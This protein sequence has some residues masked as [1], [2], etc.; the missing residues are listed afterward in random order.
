MESAQPK[1]DAATP[2]QKPSIALMR[3]LNRMKEKPEQAIGYILMIIAYTIN[4][5][6]EINLSTSAILT[7]IRI[8]SPLIV[9]YFLTRLILVWRRT[10]NSI[11]SQWQIQLFL[12]NVILSTFMAYL[13]FI[14]GD[15]TGIIAGSLWALHALASALM[16][17]IAARQYDRSNWETIRVLN[18]SVV[19]L[20]KQD[21]RIVDTLGELAGADKA[22]ANA[23]KATVEAIAALAN[24]VKMI[25]EDRKPA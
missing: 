6:S 9:W 23:D 14:T 7:M 17:H 22:L 4:I 11:A 5:F 12:S 21:T 24:T 3:H 18:E 2:D 19:T 8:V 20:T 10:P 13:A 15:I 1:P 25:V 16:W